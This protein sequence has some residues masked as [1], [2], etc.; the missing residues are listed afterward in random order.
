MKIEVRN[1]FLYLDGK[2][3]PLRSTPNRGGLIKPELVVLHDTAGRLDPKTAV[4][5]MTNPKARASAH[6]C[7]G[8]GGEITQLAPFNV[9]T[10][11]AGVSKYKGRKYVNKFSIGIEIVNPGKMTGLVGNHVSAWYKQKFNVDEFDIKYANTKDHGPGFWMAYTP[12]QI[13]A[14]TDI[15][16]V[17]VAHYVLRDVTT[18]YAISPKR[19]VDVNP[20]FPIETVRKAALGPAC[21][22]MGRA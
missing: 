9:A 1:H 6:L 2:R 7:I 16:E 8:R 10:W 15:C 22:P 4:D 20:V 5:W 13:A 11:H 19:K 12:V 3:V 21:G 17:L 18:H 14:V